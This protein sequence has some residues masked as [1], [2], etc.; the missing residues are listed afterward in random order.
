MARRTAL[1]NGAE[2]DDAWTDRAEGHLDRHTVAF[3]G[4]DTFLRNKRAAGRPKDLGQYAVPTPGWTYVI[5]PDGQRF[6]LIKEALGT[7]DRI[8]VVENWLK[9]LKR[10][11][12]IK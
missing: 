5:A 9:E 10:L 1:I 8:I 12:P 3:L 7:A 11:V 2:W 4:R 6:L